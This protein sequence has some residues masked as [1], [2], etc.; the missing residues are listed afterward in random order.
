MMNP[1]EN[2]LDQFDEEIK[3]DQDQDESYENVE[4]LIFKKDKLI[5]KYKEVDFIRILEEKL[6][7]QESTV[8]KLK[9]KAILR[10][11][12]AQTQWLKSSHIDH[13][14]EFLNSQFNGQYQSICFSETWQ[15][16][17]LF[18]DIHQVCINPN[19]DLIFIANCNNNHLIL[20]TNID[21][22]EYKDYQLDSEISHR[23][24]FIYDSMN[25]Q[26]NASSIKP[27][28]NFLYPGSSNHFVSMVK[29]VPQVGTFDCGLFCIAYAYDIARKVDPSKLKYDQK[30][31]NFIKF[32]F[33]N[34]FLSWSVSQQQREI[35]DLTI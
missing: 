12:K 4:K 6:D 25:D 29:M 13:A 9:M 8:E 30:F 7:N 35:L 22:L 34:E 16:Q 27:I 26:N 28:M 18:R 31:N 24:S 3:Q 20:L 23:Q 14:L 2:F 5:N 1:Y 32:N 21:P 19:F 17:R 10:D 11:V 33:L 15:I